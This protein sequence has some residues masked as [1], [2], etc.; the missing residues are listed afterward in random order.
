MTATEL[1]D[2]ARLRSWLAD[3][4]EDARIEDIVRITSGGANELFELTRPGRSWVL[5][6]PLQHPQDVSMANRVM[7][8]EYRLLRA[9]A[10]SD[11]AHPQPVAVCTDTDVIG[12]AFY[13]MEKVDGITTDG[14]LPE[15]LAD[16][17][18]QTAFAFEA[19]D[20]L[21]ALHR[22]D[23]RAAGL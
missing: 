3:N 20:A 10:G 1:L 11:V 22:V 21:A 17:R 14:V 18:G 16:A 23:W 4:V 13:V 8:R 5:R 19:V 6:R 2:E 12:A 9:L 15:H 7:A